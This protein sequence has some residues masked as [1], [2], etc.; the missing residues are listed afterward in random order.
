MRVFTNAAV[1]QVLSGQ[2]GTRT[3]GFNA[4]IKEVRH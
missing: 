4:Y 1:A 2:V 3:L